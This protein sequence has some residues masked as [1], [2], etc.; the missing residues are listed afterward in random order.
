MPATSGIRHSALDSVDGLAHMSRGWCVESCRQ[1]EISSKHLPSRA[2][3]SAH[4]YGRHGRWA[5]NLQALPSVPANCGSARPSR[6][7]EAFERR[8]HP[9]YVLSVRRGVASAL[10]Q[11]T[12][13]V[14]PYANAVATQLATGVSNDSGV[15]PRVPSPGRRREAARYAKTSR[16]GWR[17]AGSPSPWY[18]FRRKD[19][20]EC[21]C[22]EGLRNKWMDS[23][24]CLPQIPGNSRDR[25][26]V[27]RV[28]FPDTI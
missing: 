1:T 28:S 18:Q 6:V 15:R 3:A 2:G 16:G 14:S 26:H 8:F 25:S 19:W 4:R 23:S 10:R 22:S 27:Q 5:T 12:T 24:R 7:G 21:C 11:H 20:W 17:V 9:A 13:L